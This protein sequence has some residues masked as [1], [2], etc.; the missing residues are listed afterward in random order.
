MYIKV[1]L[2]KSNLSV[3]TP[4]IYTFVTSNATNTKYQ[5]QS[6]QFETSRYFWIKP[7]TYILSLNYRDKKN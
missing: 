7:R 5:I 3:Q 6:E 4:L 1:L 2:A